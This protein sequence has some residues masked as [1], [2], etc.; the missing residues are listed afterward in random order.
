MIQLGIDRSRTA[1]FWDRH[2]STSSYPTWPAS[3]RRLCI[4][5]H[6]DKCD[7]RSSDIYVLLFQLQ[8]WG[9][10]QCLHDLLASNSTA[11]L[12]FTSGKNRFWHT[13][14]ID[15]H[16][17]LG[18]PHVLWCLRKSYF[19]MR[20]VQ[21]CENPII[22]Y[23]HLYRPHT[24]I[25]LAE[26]NKIKNHKSVDSLLAA[27]QNPNTCHRRPLQR[28]VWPECLQPCADRSCPSSPALAQRRTK[29][30]GEDKRGVQSVCEREGVE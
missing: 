18:G 9:H 23:G 8:C 20:P 15:L 7:S 16:M 21:P 26:K 13:V 10:M 22:S 3:V 1:R 30:G 5:K 19:F 6:M 17:R 4:H 14:K 11:K 25:I 12:I 2:R 24:K 27:G 28:P 29:W